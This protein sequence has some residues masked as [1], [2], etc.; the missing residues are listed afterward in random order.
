MRLK[1]LDNDLVMSL[2]TGK[3]FALMMQD[4]VEFEKVSAQLSPTRNPEWWL[5]STDERAVYMRMLANSQAQAII[6]EYPEFFH[7]WT[8]V[9][10]KLFRDDKE[11]LM[12]M[13]INE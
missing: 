11:L 1:W 8:S 4:W 13:G 12:E 3:G 6:K 5:Q 7:V 2:D 10:L 9:M